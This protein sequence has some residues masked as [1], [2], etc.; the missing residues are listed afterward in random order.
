MVITTHIIHQI[1]L[2]TNKEQ[3]TRNTY[4]EILE[5][6]LKQADKFED[7]QKIISSHS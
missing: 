6:F 2:E 5:A 3:S 7:N 4:S 1:T